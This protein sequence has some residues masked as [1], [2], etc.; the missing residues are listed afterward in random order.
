MPVFAFMVLRGRV[1]NAGKAGGAQKGIAWDLK[2][3]CFLIVICSSI[4]H[5]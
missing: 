5:H 1:N 3:F 4:I 2:L